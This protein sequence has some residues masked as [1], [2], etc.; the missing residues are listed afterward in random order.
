MHDGQVMVGS[1]ASQQ[2]KQPTKNIKVL[3][4]GAAAAGKTSIL[5]RYFYNTFDKSSRTPTLGSDWYT[6]RISDPLIISTN[7]CDDS[8]VSL[9]AWDTPGRERFDAQHQRRQTSLGPSFLARADAIMLVYD[10]N[11]STSFK[12]LLKWY[13]ELIEI[14][15]FPILVVANKLD[16]YLAEQGRR[17]PKDHH[18]PHRV[19]QCRDVLG[20]R[21]QKFEGKDYRYEYTISRIDGGKRVQDMRMPHKKRMEVSYLADRENWTTDWSYLDSLILSE[22]GSPQTKKWLFYG[23]DAMDSNMLKSVQR[24]EVV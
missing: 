7:T 24:R 14:K 6:S 12:Q 1:S 15:K 16:L 13:A 8:F 22:D 2:V 5:R 20:V 23:A 21:K 19:E 11:S 18:H 9:Q 3:V 4:L 10:M 17:A